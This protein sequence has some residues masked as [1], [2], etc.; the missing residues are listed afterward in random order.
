MAKRTSDAPEWFERFG[1]IPAVAYSTPPD[2]NPRKLKGFGQH[3]TV[4]R[5][6]GMEPSLAW[7]SE[8]GGS[9][10][11]VHERAFQD[12]GT[13]TTPYILKNLREAL[14]LPGQTLDYHFAIQ[15]SC[16]ELWDRR[17]QEPELLHEI[18]RY[19]WLDVV[20]L[21]SQ[22]AQF[23][24]PSGDGSFLSVAAFGLL[25][26][27]YEREGALL[28]ALEVA[29]IESQFIGTNDRIEELRERLAAEAAV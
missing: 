28:E 26:S 11:P 7:G 2:V 3:P 25:L 21:Q 22:K 10:S 29:E 24:K 27:L 4:R 13:K 20:L 23:Y 18:E 19:C 5:W 6:D 17:R 14:E 8:Y 16:D 12:F 9:A 15:N 1:A